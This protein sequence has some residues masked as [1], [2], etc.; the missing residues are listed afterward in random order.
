[1]KKKIIAMLLS[2]VAVFGFFFLA[3]QNVKA[4]SGTVLVTSN[5]ASLYKGINGN[6]SRTLGINTSW[7]YSQRQDVNGQ[8]WY[9]VGNDEWVKDT[10]VSEK[11]VNAKNATGVVT[12]KSGKTATVRVSLNGRP[13]GQTLGSGTAWKYS[14]TANDVWGFTWYHVSTNGWVSSNDVQIKSNHPDYTG[15]ANTY[16]WGQ[17]TYYVKM[18]APWVGNNWGNA[19]SWA[20]SARNVGFTVDRN[21][22]AGSVIVFTAGQW[23]GDWRSDTTYG[24]V[25]YVQSVNGDSVTITQGGMGFRNP[26]GPNTQTISGAGQFQYIH[27]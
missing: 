19:T 2:V 27:R 11:A 9:L 5:G 26:T 25:A 23:V 15:Q 8:H 17:C 7:K 14:Q 1:M 10:E 21:P 24:H 4:D 20:N 22:A 12:V 6:Y 13:N 3:N 16:P 18:V